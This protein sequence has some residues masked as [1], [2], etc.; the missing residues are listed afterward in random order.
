VI[1]WASVVIVWF[2]ANSDAFVALAAL[3]ATITFVIDVRRKRK[4]DVEAEINLWRK[5]SVHKLL[6]TSPVFITAEEVLSQLRSSSFDSPVRIGK[7]KLTVEQM[8]MLL[9]EMLEAGVITQIWGDRFGIKH[10]DPQNRLSEL[11]AQGALIELELYR[12]IYLA[13]S[14]FRIDSVGLQKEITKTMGFEVQES[15]LALLLTSMESRGLIVA[16]TSGKWSPKLNY[17]ADEL[18]QTEAK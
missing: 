7:D 1:V 8:R 4:N 3:T 10:N 16:D 18:K 11:N 12:L 5:T 17:S 6:H 13:P 15:V 2:Q 9:L 14:T